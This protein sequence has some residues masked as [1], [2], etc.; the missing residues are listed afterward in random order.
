MNKE[1]DQSN[2]NFKNISQYISDQIFENSQ[3]KTATKRNSVFLT[4]IQIFS[5]NESYK[6]NQLILG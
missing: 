4:R 1:M 5:T 6:L 3:M 2:G